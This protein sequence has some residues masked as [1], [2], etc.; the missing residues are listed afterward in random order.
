MLLQ[1]PVK[2]FLEEVAG[3]G[4]MLG[5]MMGLALSY[6]KKVVIRLNLEMAS[7]MVLLH[8]GQIALH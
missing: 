7:H 8:N 1:R 5:T 6:L 4:K 2:Y 3:F